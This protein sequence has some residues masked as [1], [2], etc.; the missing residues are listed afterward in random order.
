MI[1]LLVLFIAILA[2]III[3]GLIA[4]FSVILIPAL[5]IVGFVLI[6]CFVFKLLFGRKKK[7]KEN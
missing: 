2:I 1:T 6:D 3:A 5:F 7:K 4:G